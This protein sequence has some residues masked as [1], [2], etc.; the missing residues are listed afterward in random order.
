MI[1]SRWECY[2]F[3]VFSNVYEK[4]E[5]LTSWNRYVGVCL[6]GSGINVK[7]WELVFREPRNVNWHPPGG[8]VGFMFFWDFLWNLKK[9]PSRFLLSKAQQEHFSVS[10]SDRLTEI[11][12]ISTA[13]TLYFMPSGLH[14]FRSGLILCV[15]L[16]RVSSS[17]R[18]PLDWRLRT[19]IGNDPGWRADRGAE[20]A[21][22]PVDPLPKDLFLP[23]VTKAHQKVFFDV[24]G[25]NP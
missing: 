11:C 7:Q 9:K 3:D 14:L 25:G 15:C 12:K 22:R 21:M 23:R 4:Q 8:G 18:E 13:M 16:S 6:L 17:S 5:T 1:I 2:F 20:T 10:V 19:E 24:Q